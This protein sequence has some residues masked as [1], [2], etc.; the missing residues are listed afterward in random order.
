MR[1]FLSCVI[2]VPYPTD[3]YSVTCAAIFFIIIKHFKA[4][5]GGIFNEI[6][7]A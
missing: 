4:F 5:Y 6:Q 2:N 3:I 7:Y 1:S